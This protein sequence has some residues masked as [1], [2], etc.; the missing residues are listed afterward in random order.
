MSAES[1]KQSVL[2]VG[3]STGVTV[4]EITPAVAVSSGFFNVTESQNTNT[5]PPC[6]PIR[7]AKQGLK[8]MAVVYIW[9][10]NLQAFES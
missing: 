7:H 4:F 9:E 6:A 2:V 8:N 1:R 5:K 3:A 10:E